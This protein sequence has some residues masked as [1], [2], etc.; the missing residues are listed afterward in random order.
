[1]S[2]TKEDEIKVLEEQKNFKEYFYKSLF[3]NW[4]VFCIKLFIA[5]IFSYIFI[6]FDYFVEFRYFF[7]YFL[8][9]LIY[10]N[11]LNKKILSP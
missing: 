7:A 3:V 8:V 11:Y 6:L 2:I 9:E 5:F 1:M 10:F 4:K